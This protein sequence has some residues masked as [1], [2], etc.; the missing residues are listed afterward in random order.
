MHLSIGEFPRNTPLNQ[1]TGAAVR[2]NDLSFISLKRKTEDQIMQCLAFNFQNTLQHYSSNDKNKRNKTSNSFRENEKMLQTQCHSEKKKKYNYKNHRSQ[3]T[4]F[5]CNLTI[6]SFQLLKFF[7]TKL[8]IF[9]T[10]QYQNSERLVTEMS[11]STVVQPNNSQ[12]YQN[13]QYPTA[14]QFHSF[15]QTQEL[16]DRSCFPIKYNIQQHWCHPR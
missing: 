5:S 8:R 2:P 7:Q 6:G 3:S 16:N 9:P 4:S 15:N 13:E 11:V 12:Q 14:V 10:N 1:I